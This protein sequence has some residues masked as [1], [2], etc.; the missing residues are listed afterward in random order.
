MYSLS[1]SVIYQMNTL[2]SLLKVCHHLP[3]EKEVLLGYEAGR[4]HLETPNGNSIA[5]VGCE[6]ILYMRHFQVG[7]LSGIPKSLS[8]PPSSKQGHFL[9]AIIFSS[10]E[11]VLPG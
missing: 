10:S 5:D 9:I 1:L 3:H 6:P 11:W 8:L 7:F 4:F 2:S